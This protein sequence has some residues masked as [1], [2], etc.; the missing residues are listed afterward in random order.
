MIGCDG[1]K[2]GRPVHLYLNNMSNKQFMKGL[3]KLNTFFWQ[4]SQNGHVQETINLVQGAMH[5]QT[6][7]SF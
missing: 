4:A 7:A 3:L 2:G 1:I 5:A 6:T